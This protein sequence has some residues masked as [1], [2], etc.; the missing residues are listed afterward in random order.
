[1]KSRKR[2]HTSKTTPHLENDIKSRKRHLTFR[3]HLVGTLEKLPWQIRLSTQNTFDKPATV[4]SLPKRFFMSLVK[5]G[6]I[7]FLFASVKD[8]CEI[9][10]R[11]RRYTSF[12]TLR[13]VCQNAERIRTLNASRSLTMIS[14]DSFS[15]NANCCSLNNVSS[16]MVLEKLLNFISSFLFGGES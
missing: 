15:T 11:F 6:D 2:H 7:I 12:S 10:H 16:S 13:V 5:M 1:M 4:M 8:V 9:T 14:L 3:I